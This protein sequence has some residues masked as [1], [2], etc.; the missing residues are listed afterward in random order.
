[1]SKKVT[2][3]ADVRHILAIPDRRI[4]EEILDLRRSD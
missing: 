1:L 3:L 2:G 4:A